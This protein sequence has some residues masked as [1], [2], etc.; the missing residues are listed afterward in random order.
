MTL[1]TIQ[2]LSWGSLPEP[3]RKQLDF[4]SLYSSQVNAY[5]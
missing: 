2:P 1:Q 5:M 4:K 3:K